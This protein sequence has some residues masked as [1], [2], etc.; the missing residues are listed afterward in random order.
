MHVLSLLYF[1]I[2]FILFSK[3]IDFVATLYLFH[4]LEY[5]VLKCYVLKIINQFIH[6]HLSQW[7][8]V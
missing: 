4:T 3:E 1:P 8:G 5:K 6:I 2:I 7:D